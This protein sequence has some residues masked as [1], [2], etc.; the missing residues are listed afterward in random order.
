MIE[1]QTRNSPCSHKPRTCKGGG[2]CS[3]WRSANASLQT[4]IQTPATYQ[5]LVLDFS[6]AP[7]EMMDTRCIQQPM[8]TSQFSF[9]VSNHACSY[10]WAIGILSTLLAVHSVASPG[11]FCPLASAITTQPASRQSVDQNIHT[12]KKSLFIQVHLWL[13]KSPL[14]QSVTSHT[15]CYLRPRK[16]VTIWASTPHKNP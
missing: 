3:F 16:R 13:K 11:L 9:V 15:L 5:A 4:S 12:G 6:S 2:V 10:L 8:P 1:C 7:S 14:A